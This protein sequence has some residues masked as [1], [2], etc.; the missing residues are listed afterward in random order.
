MDTTPTPSTNS[1]KGGDSPTIP[2]GLPSKPPSQD[3]QTDGQPNIQRIETI[4]NARISDLQGAVKD[5]IEHKLVFWNA[6]VTH[7]V[8]LLLVLTVSVFT[9]VF[10]L[11]TA[12][13]SSDGRF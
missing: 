12:F 11:F 5:D 2:I 10:F 6:I 9:P 1:L 13:V 7:G 4:G 8:T 3:S